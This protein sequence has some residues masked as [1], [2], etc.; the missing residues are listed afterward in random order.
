[1]IFTMTKRNIV[2]PYGI[3]TRR[4]A[5]VLMS[6]SDRFTNVD[7]PDTRYRVHRRRYGKVIEAQISYRITSQQRCYMLWARAI[8]METGAIAKR[9]H[10]H[11][12]TIR[13]YLKTAKLDLTKFAEAEFITRREHTGVVSFV[14]NYCLSVFSAEYLRVALFHCWRHLFDPSSK[15]DK[16]SEMER[17]DLAE[18]YGHHIPS[19]QP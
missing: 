7:F 10:C 1:M 6:L 12:D 11:K 14:C 18:K 3:T 2:I 15:M 8:G 16:E 19:G 5:T 4:R 13:S 9:V 17:S